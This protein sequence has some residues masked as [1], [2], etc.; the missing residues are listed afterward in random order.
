VWMTGINS[1]GTLSGWTSLASTL[2]AGRT[3]HATAAGKGY[4]YVIGGATNGVYYAR[5]NADGTVGTWN[6]T[7]NYPTTLYSAA[8]VY[9]EGRLYVTGGSTANNY[10]CNNTNAVYSAAVNDDGTLGS[11]TAL[12][13]MPAGRAGHGLAVVNG[14]LYSLGGAV[15]SGCADIQNYPG[16]SVYGAPFNADGT[17]GA[18]STLTSLPGTNVWQRAAA[19][20]GR[21]YVMGGI[22]G[23]AGQNS[24][25]TAV[26][27]ADGTIGPWSSLTSFGST[28]GGGMF[29]LGGRIYSNQGPNGA[30]VYITSLN[31]GN[32]TQYFAE[33]ATDSGFTVGLANTGWM[34]GTNWSFGALAAGTTYYFRAK[35]RNLDAV[36]TGFTVLGSTLTGALIGTVNAPAVSTDT[37]LD[38]GPNNLTVQWDRNG[39]PGG[40]INGSYWTTTTALP[41]ARTAGTLVMA[42]QWAYY[43]GGNSGAGNQSTVYY[44]AVSAAGTIGTWSTVAAL[45]AGISE[46]GAGVQGGRLYVVGYDG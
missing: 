6:T 40:E 34:F 30:G 20:S 42:G 35:A 18:W 4:L 37:V 15:Q 22:N 11:W 24:F 32:F 2:P 9:R 19:S 33:R 25:Y 44:A 17:L 46:H 41:A 5:L 39:N 16:S 12:A 43:L 13:G 8:A 7:T 31:T 26:V 38:A 27:N 28:Y 3:Y 10:S 21:L 14:R 36:E 1:D 45:P 29:S 23:G